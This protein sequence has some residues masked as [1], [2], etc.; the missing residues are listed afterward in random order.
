MFRHRKHLPV[1]FLYD[2]RLLSR[3]R[4]VFCR[5]DRGGD[6]ADIS[7]GSFKISKHQPE[8]CKNLPCN[9]LAST[10]FS[11]PASSPSPELCSSRGFCG[12]AGAPRAPRTPSSNKAHATNIL[13]PRITRSSDPRPSDQDAARRRPH[14]L[15]IQASCHNRIKVQLGAT[16]SSS[17][18]PYAAAV[19]EQTGSRHRSRGGGRGRISD[20]QRG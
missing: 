20:R 15:R 17:Q 13:Q 16:D 9:S 12:S 2:K 10:T 7:I 3:R 18:G 8:M 4:S 6:L 11:K 14:Q 1:P 19:Q 5:K